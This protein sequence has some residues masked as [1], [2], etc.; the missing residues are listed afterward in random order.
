MLYK[1]IEVFALLYCIVFIMALVAVK[2][3]NQ[4]CA[5]ATQNNTVISG[6]RSAVLVKKNIEA[7]ERGITVHADNLYQQTA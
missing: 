7:S 4:T 2:G 6:Y 3:A 1:N 5:V